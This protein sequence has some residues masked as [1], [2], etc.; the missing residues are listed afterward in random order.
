M[1]EI[2]EVVIT[3][4]YLSKLINKEIT[5]FKILSGRYSHQ[6]MRGKKLLKNNLPL[7]IQ[8]ID[9][10]G[11]FMW[12]KLKNNDVTLYLMCTFGLTGEWT[13][14][15]K[16]TND[17]DNV[18][19]KFEIE[20][21]D[22]LYF[23]DQRNFGT[24]QITDD[25][26]VVKKKLNELGPD[27]L[28]TEF[29]LKEFKERL[30]SSKVNQTISIVKI[31][32]DQT[33]KGIGSGL[34]NYLAPEILYASKISPYRTIASLSPL[35][36]KKLYNSLKYILKLSYVNNNI[37]YMGSFKKFMSTHKKKISDGVY[38]DYIPS[39]D[40]DDEKFEFKVYMKKNDPSGNT[41]KKDNIIGER[42]TYWVPDVQK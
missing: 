8:K 11:K 22:N 20:K 26:E 23:T 17:D 5:G 37:G 39:V 6:D 15:A 33:K 1:P 7:I 34:G 13:I 36:I 30:Y 4:Q 41:V 9:T 29:E 31:L 12:F 25:Y 40:V 35:E 2:S 28:K 18:R 19:V 14:K 3:S 21:K 38:P 42:S 24:L 32:M 10:K 27:L 16:N